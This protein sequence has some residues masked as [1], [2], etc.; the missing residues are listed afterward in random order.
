MAKCEY[1]QYNIYIH[2]YMLYIR[3]YTILYIYIYK[4]AYNI[5][6]GPV[7]FAGSKKILQLTQHHSGSLVDKM[8]HSNGR[9]SMMWIDG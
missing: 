9:R 1:T 3:L 4:D 2:I 6:E 8:K 5:V 7:Y